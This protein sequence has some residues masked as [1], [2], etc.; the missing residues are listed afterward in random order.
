ML[1]KFS[2]RPLMLIELVAWAMGVASLGFYIA[3]GSIQAQSAGDGLS[4][5]ASA[6]T[7]GA[8]D[9]SSQHLEIG[10]LNTTT[11]SPQRIKEYEQSVGAAGL[12]IAVLRIPAVHLNVPIYEGTSD[13]ILK[14]GAG[15]IEGTAQLNEYGN[16]AVAAHRDSFFRLLKD[17]VAGDVIAIETMHGTDHYRVRKTWIVSPTDVSVLS[18]TDS[19]ALT[20]VTCYPFYF[21]GAAPQRFI[22]RAERI[23]A[24]SDSPRALARR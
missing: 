7:V 23:A 21:V 3:E 22:V 13:E 5:F 4:Y 9:S 18:A 16:S 10:A 14:R 15:H 2:K 12:P 6:R 17:I 1:A 24:T 20:L 19:Q 11:W 8:N